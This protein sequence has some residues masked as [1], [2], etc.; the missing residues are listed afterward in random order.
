MCTTII[1]NNYYPLQCAY[2]NE[3]HT[4]PLPASNN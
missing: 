4:R 2:K 1:D 3:K